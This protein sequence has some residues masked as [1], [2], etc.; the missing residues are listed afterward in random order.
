MFDISLNSLLSWKSL[1]SSPRDGNRVTKSRSQSV[2][3]RDD[4]PVSLAAKAMNAPFSRN[5]HVQHPAVSIHAPSA[6]T[7]PHTIGKFMDYMSLVI[8]AICP[9]PGCFY[10]LSW[11][12]A[13]VPES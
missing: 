12:Q 2:G 10:V 5:V 1:V 6:N 13:C 9:G 8:L 11:L 3:G 7:T 4:K